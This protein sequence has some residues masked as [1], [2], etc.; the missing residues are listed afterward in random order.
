MRRKK[1][2]LDLGFFNGTIDAIFHGHGGVG[3]FGISLSDVR[4]LAKTYLGVDACST[5]WPDGTIAIYRNRARKCGDND[6]VFADGT[7]SPSEA[8]S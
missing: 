4:R 7:A 8:Q 3:R 2:D 6:G 5:R 1:Y